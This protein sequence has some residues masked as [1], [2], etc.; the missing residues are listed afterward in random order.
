L[1]NKNAQINTELEKRVLLKQEQAL[2]RENS[3]GKRGRFFTNT[4]RQM[5]KNLHCRQR[6][7]SRKCKQKLKDSEDMKKGK[8]SASTIRCSKTAPKNSTETWAQ[9]MLRPKNPHLWQQESLTG[10]QCG[11]KKHS[12]MDRG[13]EVRNY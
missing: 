11:E 5:S 7:L 2:L 9:R 4:E 10:S 8:P 6:K 1:D 12:R 13:R 3:T